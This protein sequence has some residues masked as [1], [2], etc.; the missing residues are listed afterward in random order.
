[1][2][3]PWSVYDEKCH[4]NAS[5]ENLLSAPRAAELMCSYDLRGN[6]IEINEALERA[7]GYTRKEVRSMNLSDLLDTE[8]LEAARL[9]I[10]KHVGGAS[11]EPRQVVV[12]ARD[13]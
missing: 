11:P 4:M 8:S 6:I 2:S 9:D 7:I 10:L 1:M 3:G 5:A 12:R 13:G